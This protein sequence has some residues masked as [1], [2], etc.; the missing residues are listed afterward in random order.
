MNI[1]KKMLYVAIPIVL[2]FLGLFYSLLHKNKTVVIRSVQSESEKPVV[3]ENKDDINNKIEK[4]KVKDDALGKNEDKD[5]AKKEEKDENFQE[6]ILE[7]AVIE[8]TKKE[9][10]K[11]NIKDIKIKNKLV[12]WGFTKSNGR[13]IDTI[14]LHSSY[15]ALGDNPYD[16][17]GLILEYKQYGV[18]P[19]YLIDRKGSIYRLVKDKDI[20]WHAGVSK[21]PDGRKNVNNF[22]IGIE[23]M[24]TKTDDYT[25]KQYRAV[26]SLIDYLKKEYKIKYVLGHNE[27]SPGRKTDP[28]NFDWEKIK[29]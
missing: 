10:D 6:K 18:S 28:W 7:N 12:S 15:D 19:H 20:A 3:K 26:Q 22:S 24:N 11:K 2:L 16:L 14:I 9:V 1:F 21:L 5:N 4:M 23:I 8:K 25:K 17:K 13:K 29:R 27:I